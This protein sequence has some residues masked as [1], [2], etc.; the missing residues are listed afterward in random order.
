VK[1]FRA[2]R[3]L[4]QALTEGVCARHS[5]EVSAMTSARTGDEKRHCGWRGFGLRLLSH[6]Q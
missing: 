1:R 3:T 5:A 2:S 6:Q 4:R